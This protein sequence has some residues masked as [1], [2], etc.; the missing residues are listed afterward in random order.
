MKLK[1]WFESEDGDSKYEEEEG[2]TADMKTARRRM[3]RTRF[4]KKKKRKKK[5]VHIE[6]TCKYKRKDED[7]FT[8][9]ATQPT[10]TATTNIE[11]CQ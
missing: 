11:K 10:A 6:N 8:N 9:I 5:R 4:R 2:V 1:K 3:E 7:I